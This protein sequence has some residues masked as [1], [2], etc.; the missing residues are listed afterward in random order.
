[1]VQFY[2]SF[3]EPITTTCLVVSLLI[4]CCAYIGISSVLTLMLP[5]YLQDA[6]APLPHAFQEHRS[7]NLLT[8]PSTFIIKNK[9]EG[10]GGIIGNSLYQIFFL[11]YSF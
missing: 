6:A 5:Y 2:S 9:R 11:I 7:I 1:M 8:L 4:V 3:L 10:W